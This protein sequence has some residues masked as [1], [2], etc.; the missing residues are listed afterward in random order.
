MSG[1]SKGY[2]FVE[3][4]SE[5]DAKDAYYVSSICY[6]AASRFFWWWL[7]RILFFF[8]LIIYY[9][10]RP[11]PRN[12]FWPYSFCYDSHFILFILYSNRLYSLLFFWPCFYLRLNF[13]CFPFLDSMYFFM[14]S[15]LVDFFLGDFFLFRKLINQRLMEPRFD[16]FYFFSILHQC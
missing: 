14:S 9:S 3:Y 8:F 15:I 13:A 10:S 12:F 1:E 11:R 7:D 16:S 5:R 2:A 6:C 4:L